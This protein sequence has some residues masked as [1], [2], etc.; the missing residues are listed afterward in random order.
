MQSRVCRHPDLFSPK[1]SSLCATCW[2]G[3]LHRCSFPV[4]LWPSLPLDVKWLAAAD[5]CCLCHW[6]MAKIPLPVHTTLVVVSCMGLLVWDSRL[7]CGATDCTASSE[8]NV[9]HQEGTCLSKTLFIVWWT[10][11]Y[12]DICVTGSMLQGHKCTCQHVTGIP[13]NLT[14]CY[15]DTIV[16]D[17]MLQGLQCAWQHATGTWVF[18]STCYRDF[19]VPDSMLQE[20]QSAWQHA[21]GT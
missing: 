6:F 11:L 14:T 2:C 15:R 3:Y 13:L 17:N 19:S 12:R 8:P 16:P 4:L 7:L 9:Q 18:L 20:L 10:A 5:N 1:G 21:T